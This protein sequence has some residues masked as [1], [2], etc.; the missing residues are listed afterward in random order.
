MK[1]KKWFKSA[2]PGQTIVEILMATAVVAVVLTA[3]AGA[4]TF[5]VKNS[6]ESKYKAVATQK[7]QEAVEIFRRERAVL[8]WETFTETLQNGEYCFNE[9]PADSAAFQALTPATCSEGVAEAGTE[10]TRQ[11]LVTLQDNGTEVTQVQVES[12][13]TWYDGKVT[14]SVRATQQLLD[15]L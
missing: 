10:F 14:R 6:A 7:A 13:V 4:L 8:G 2:S 3:V 15:T 12:E 5:T 1:R 11:V 9:L